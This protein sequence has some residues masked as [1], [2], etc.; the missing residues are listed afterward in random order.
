M[1]N[2]AQGVNVVVAG[3]VD[4]IYDVVEVANRNDV[5]HHLYSNYCQYNQQRH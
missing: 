4:D 3:D 2:S 5:R 1:L